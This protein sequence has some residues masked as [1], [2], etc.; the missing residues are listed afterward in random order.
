MKVQA[1]LNSNEHDIKNLV[2]GEDQKETKSNFKRKF[3]EC[4]V[5]LKKNIDERDLFDEIV[6]GFPTM[7]KEIDQ[8]LVSAADP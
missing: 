5:L 1:F 6:K 8:D 3:D 2:Y 7:R 4:R